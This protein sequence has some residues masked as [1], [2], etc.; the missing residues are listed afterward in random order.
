MDDRTRVGGSSGVTTGKTPTVEDQMLDVLNNPRISENAK[1]AE[2]EKIAEKLPETEK[3]ALYERLKD[4][5]SQ[6]PLAKQFHYRLS[7]HPD[8]PGQLSTVDKVLT[9]L[10]PDPTKA[11]AP[12]PPDAKTTS[13]SKGAS[14]SPVAQKTADAVARDHF[15]NQQKQTN[16]GPIIQNVIQVP[17]LPQYAKINNV[18][19]LL[20][21]ASKD[22]FRKIIAESENWPKESRE[23]LTGAMSQSATIMKRI[24]KELPADEQA[25]AIDRTFNETPGFDDQYAGPTKKVVHGAV[26][27]A[28]MDSA[29]K[30]VLNQVI[31]KSQNGD[32][33]AGAIQNQINNS[34]FGNFDKL[35]TKLKG[36]VL[37]MA[38]QDPAVGGVALS[39]AFGRLSP[40]EKNA[41][42]DL[43]QQDKRDT[44]P[45]F[46]S[47][48]AYNLDY[49]TM[50]GLNKENAE[51]MRRTFQFL[52]DHA[53]T[54]EEKDAY[55]KSAHYVSEWM[56]EAF[57]QAPAN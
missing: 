44:L 37:D 20:E 19:Q 24:A 47:K 39:Q 22:D 15:V 51:A 7:H 5:K 13:P 40:G 2:L 1:V 9:A 33:I 35:D 43:F 34:D 3:K 55:S 4:R 31:R 6:D 48:L 41:I 52:A 16:M 46:L 18:Q 56:E 28:W 32:A 30:D 10:K 38:A 12:P 21:S 17:N 57:K 49:S 23:I 42:F 54:D 29:P 50:K 11:S 53:K 14:P 25:K 45:D 8:K 36:A 27:R 26:L